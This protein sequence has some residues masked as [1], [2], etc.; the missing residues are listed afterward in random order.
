MNFNLLNFLRTQINQSVVLASALISIMI[1]GFGGSMFFIT[2]DSI[3]DLLSTFNGFSKDLNQQN[4]LVRSMALVHSN[5]IWVGSETDAS[6]RII[7]TEVVD[8][9]AQDLNRKLEVC[10]ARCI[11][12][13]K[14]FAIYFQKWNEIKPLAQRNITLSAFREN[15]ESQM[16]P[17]A[18]RLFDNL[19]KESGVVVKDGQKNFESSVERKYKMLVG[20]VFLLLLIVFTTITFFRYIRISLLDPL[21]YLRSAMGKVSLDLNTRVELHETQVLELAEIA[22]AF[23][24]MVGNLQASELKI[25]QQNEIMIQTAKMASLG[26]MSAG[27][28]HEINNPL[29]IISGTAQQLE[30]KL[31]ANPELN[32]QVSKLMERIHRSVHR[33]SKIVSGL[34]TFARDSSGDPKTPESVRKLIE[35]TFELVGE[36]FRKANIKLEIGSVPE[37]S[38]DCRAS[39]M[40]QVFVNLLG[41]SMDALLELPE[42]DHWVKIETELAGPMVR[43]RVTDGGHGI[44]EDVAAK[45]MDP[46]FTTKEVGKGT[47]L[48]LSI[49]IGIVKEHGGNLILERGYPNTSFVIELPVYSQAKAA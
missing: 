49:S 5:L 38:I 31:K 17:L 8:E 7:R 45:I 23:N 39:E 4:A 25:V 19:D 27:V 29:A 43:I 35:D 42:Q 12:L 24:E 16:N 20:A 36:R 11:D 48:G 22:K 41:N 28:A 2:Y 47:G 46:F 1:L 30:S 18:E 9:F 15:V 3:K 6:R 10:G 21:Q 40:E 34:K 13:R 37:I 26:Q 44:P 33:I 14:E 32:L